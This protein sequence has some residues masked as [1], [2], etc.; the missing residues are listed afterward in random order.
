MKIL[1]LCDQGNN[2]SVVLAS[3][4]KYCG[5]GHDILTAGLER[6]APDTIMYLGLWAEK[7]ILTE[8]IQW[9]SFQNRGPNGVLTHKVELWNIGPDKYPRPHNKELLKIVTQLIEEHP[10][11]KQKTQIAPNLP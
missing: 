5:D 7:I 2:R 10:E 11:L 3:R 9:M 8:A 1:I 6:N 4:L